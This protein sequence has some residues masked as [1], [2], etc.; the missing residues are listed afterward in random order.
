MASIQNPLAAMEL[1]EEAARYIGVLERRVMLLTA[2]ELRFRALLEA[3]TGESWDDQYQDLDQDEMDRLVE[4]S[5]VKSLGISKADA[6][7]MV[8]ANKSNANSDRTVNG[9]A[10]VEGLPRL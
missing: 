9:S 2:Q 1:T 4:D 10:A 7:K 3:I 8:E 5:L 6:R